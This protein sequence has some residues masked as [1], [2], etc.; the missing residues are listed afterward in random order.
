MKLRTG[1]TSR[2]AL[3]KTSGDHRSP[4]RKKTALNKARLLARTSICLALPQPLLG[5]PFTNGSFELPGN[6]PQNSFIAVTNNAFNV[7]SLLGWSSMG[8]VQY[9]NGQASS[10]N[11]PPVD[12]SYH[13]I[14]TGENVGG[15]AGSI[16]QTFDT[17][18]N[19]DYVV[20]FFVGRISAQSLGLTARVFDDLADHSGGSFANFTARPP[21]QG[22][23][24]HQFLLTA[25]SAATT[26]QFL[27][28]FGSRYALDGVTV[29]L[30]DV[31]TLAPTSLIQPAS[32]T[33]VVAES[34]AF[35]LSPVS[36]QPPFQYQW[37]YNGR[38]VAGATNETLILTNV[39][40]SDTGSYSAIIVNV[41]GAVLSQE[42]KLVVL[43]QVPP[44]ITAQPQNVV[45][46]K[47]KQATFS[48]AATG[49]PLPTFQWFHQDASIP[50]ATNSAY[51]LANVQAGDGGSYSVVVSNPAGVVRSVTVSLT[52]R[53][54]L[55]GKK[56]SVTR[57]FQYSID[58][59][60]GRTYGIEASEDL[61]QWTSLSDVTNTNALSVFIE[62]TATNKTFRFY[63]A[64]VK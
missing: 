37:L 4:P 28:D 22:Y 46:A 58:G 35:R 45:A 25:K 24:R 57:G 18:A 19:H 42:V 38:N 60:N 27:G 31:I 40:Q 29:D 50:G 43:P 36:V 12:G 51:S 21:T 44:A 2:T 49:T 6:L 13:L 52:I 47:G 9:V 11:F 61:R 8:A 10:A 34:V 33:N 15:T 20:T 14:F 30:I 59:E 1:L 55:I 3:N 16:W 53:P 39:K 23:A 64:R 48:V 63:R 7:S 54:Q 26:L 56:L 62:P 32:K 5:S 41:T 17:V